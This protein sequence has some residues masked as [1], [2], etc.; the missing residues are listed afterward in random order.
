M[1]GFLAD[2]LAGAGVLASATAGLRAAA[3]TEVMGLTGL[4]DMKETFKKT[5]FKGPI[6][7]K[8]LQRFVTAGS[9]TNNIKHIYGSKMLSGEHQRLPSSHL[10]SQYPECFLPGQHF[11]IQQVG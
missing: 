5:A 11:L 6:R 1:E 3:L 2:S 10:K 4:L 8:N 9:G 7:Q